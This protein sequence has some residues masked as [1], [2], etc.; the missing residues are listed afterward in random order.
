[1]VG[2]TDRGRS[3]GDGDPPPVVEGPSGG[4]RASRAMIGARRCS[5]ASCSRP[6]VRGARSRE[7]SSRPRRRDGGDWKVPGGVCDRVVGESVAV[8]E[9]GD[10]GPRVAQPASSVGSSTRSKRWSQAS[11]PRPGRSGRCAARA[12]PPLISHELAL[13]RQTKQSSRCPSPVKDPHKG[14]EDLLY[15]FAFSKDARQRGSAEPRRSNGP[16]QE[17]SGS[18]PSMLQFSVPLTDL[19]APRP[20]LRMRPVIFPS[21]GIICGASRVH[22]SNHAT[23]SVLQRRKSNGSPSRKSAP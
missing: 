3:K 12:A 10:H 11:R 8:G 1:L 5:L 19:R 6:P 17:N 14:T 18:P 7:S 16:F 22:A 4:L 20:G 2:I 13:A 23:A 9:L 21:V 15:E